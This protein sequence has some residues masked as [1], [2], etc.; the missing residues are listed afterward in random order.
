MP[1][2]RRGRP[3]LIGVAA[4]SAV[5]AGT[6]GRV[7]RRQQTRWAQQDEAQYEEQSPAPAA[8]PAAEPDYTSELEKL[9]K[10]RD[11]GVIT[12]E[13][14]EAKKKQQLGI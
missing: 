11:E 10:L 7:Q 1:L 4:R 8:P 6:V 3:G 14:F 9:A 13:D 5:A 2:V 12:P